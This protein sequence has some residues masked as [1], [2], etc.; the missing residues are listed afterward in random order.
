MTFKRPSDEQLLNE[1][2]QQGRA[3][4]ENAILSL[5]ATTEA[6]LSNAEIADQLGL[7]SSG[8]TG[9]R[10][11]LTWSVLQKLVLEDRVQSLPRPR[12]K[13]GVIYRVEKGA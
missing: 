8:K 13:S 5:L 10:N 11:Y 9:Q 4:I 2:A 3:M 1:Q 12:S 6:G 7:K